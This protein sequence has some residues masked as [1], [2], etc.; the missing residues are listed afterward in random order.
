MVA[1][2]GALVIGSSGFPVFGLPSAG[3]GL[4]SAAEISTTNHAIP[5]TKT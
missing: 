5:A 4:L 2:N 3:S 1:S